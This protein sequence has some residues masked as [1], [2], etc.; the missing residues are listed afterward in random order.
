MKWVKGGWGCASK[1]VRLLFG[2]K[3]LTRGRGVFIV[4]LVCI[5]KL[6][7]FGTWVS[8]YTVFLLL[9]LISFHFLW[10]VLTCCKCK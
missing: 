1:E 3:V 10:L 4:A 5:G 8:A 7:P 2:E 6:K 9:Y